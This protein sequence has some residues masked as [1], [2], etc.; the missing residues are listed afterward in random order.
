MSKLY[1]QHSASVWSATGTLSGS[2]A[3]IGGSISGS[4][5]FG[6]P[7][8]ARLVGT[9]YL[10]ASTQ[11][12]SGWQVWQ[13]SDGGQNWDCKSA[14]SVLAAGGSGLSYEVVGNAVMIKISNG[15]SANSYRTSW[16]LRPV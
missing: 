13:S 4:F 14:C 6:S 3:G 9:I 10:S 5:A 8:Y 1:A 15:S 7:A 11:S 2:D 12:G 16:W